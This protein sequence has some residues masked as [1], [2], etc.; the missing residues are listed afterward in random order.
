M[1][2]SKWSKEV[3][4]KELLTLYKEDKMLVPTQMAKLYGGLYHACIRYYGSYRKALES[5]NIPYQQ[6]KNRK[7]SKEV[8]LEEIKK[9]QKNNES[10]YSSVVLKNHNHLYGAARRYFGSYLK[11][12]EASGIDHNKIEVEYKKE[13][14]IKKIQSLHKEGKPIHYRGVK[15]SLTMSAEKYFGSYE[16][17]VVAAGFKYEKISK[18]VKW[19]K[20][21]IVSEIR[22]LLREEKS[23]LQKDVDRGLVNASIKY[24]GSYENAL[25]VSGVDYTK[26]DQSWSQ[27]RIIALLK[28]RE[29]EGLGLRKKD[30]LKNDSKLYSAACYHFGQYYKAVEA[31]GFDYEEI[32]NS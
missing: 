22:K 1:S 30:L 13:E 3:I 25:M 24:F 15:R 9:R 29:K 23:L 19:D 14:I 12:L 21:I 28:E 16:N 26:I 6:L 17:A 27:S 20:N 32:L 31:C 11:A 2:K 10:L 4:E 5:A 8:V 18:E 7:W